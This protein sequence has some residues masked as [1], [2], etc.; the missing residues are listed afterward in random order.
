MW[1]GELSCSAGS[2]CG[3]RGEIRLQVDWFVPARARRSVFILSFGALLVVSGCQRA[4]SADVV[5]T[6]NGKEL[7]RA[8]LEKIYKANLDPSQQEPSPEQANIVRL[9][10]LDSMIDDE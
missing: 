2:C 4:P 3:S 9:K 1:V 5:A 6:V 10:T 7:M 8:D